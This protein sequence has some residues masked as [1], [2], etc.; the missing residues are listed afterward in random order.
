MDAAFP[1]ADPNE[2]RAGADPSAVPDQ[3]PS[4]GQP[5]GAPPDAASPPEQLDPAAELARVQADYQQTQAQLA[6]ERQQRQQYEQQLGAQQRQVA[7]NAA[8]QWAQ[9]EQEL[10]AAIPEMDP[11]Q[12]IETTRRFYQ[13]REQQ[14]LGTYQQTQA[15]VHQERVAA[16]ARDIIQE[17]GLDPN[18]AQRLLSVGLT[19]HPNAMVQE[20]DAIK[21]ARESSTSETTQLRQEI[22]NLKRQMTGAGLRPAWQTGG[23]NGNAP[24]ASKV[25]PGTAD[26]NSD[27]HL[28]ALLGIRR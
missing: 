12:A 24:A 11:D 25:T 3:Q 7:E 16:F 2:L 19:V 6:A 14:L 17:K 4:D 23:G 8:R 18:D 5:D 22:D 10:R 9:A 13:A 21:Q 1:N 28:A 15:Q 26:Y 27:D 20:A